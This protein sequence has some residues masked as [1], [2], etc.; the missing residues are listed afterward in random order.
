MA[1]RL[2]TL[3]R[4]AFMVFFMFAVTCVFISAVSAL[5]IVTRDA[6]AR[7]ETLFLKRAVLE[8]AGLALPASLTGIESLYKAAVQP[9]PREDAPAHYRI[10][11]PVSGRPN[12]Y[13]L[14]R[15]GAGLW[16][17][18]TATVGLNRELDVLTGVS[19][20]EH[21][22]TPGLGARVEEPWYKAQFRNKSG[23]FRLVP[24]GTR[25]AAPTDIDAITGATITSAAVRDILN[26]ALRD[27]PDIVK[28]GNGEEW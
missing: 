28:A 6:V 18:I 21:N 11:E 1:D 15:R 24:E 4:G 13:V 25:S 8:A 14:L 17:T 22:E 9:I 2:T 19:F 10:R 16:G 3:R 27:A 20:V 7:N 23:P 26:A 5:H 12:G